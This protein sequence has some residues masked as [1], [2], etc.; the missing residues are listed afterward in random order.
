LPPDQE[1]HFRQSLQPFLKLQ[2][3]HRRRAARPFAK[4]DET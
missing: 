1:E 2:A 3:K 4:S